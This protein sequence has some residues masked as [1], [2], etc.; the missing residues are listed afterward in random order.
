MTVNPTN[1]YV[2][3]AEEQA[4][5]LIADRL[6]VQLLRLHQPVH[7]ASEQARSAAER[8][9]DA[10]ISIANVPEAADAVA[11]LDSMTLVQIR[12][13]EFAGD[14]TLHRLTIDTS[15]LSQLAALPAVLWIDLYRPPEPS[16]QREVHLTL[17]DTL[18]TSTGILGPVLGDHRQWIVDKGLGGYKTAVRLAILDTGFDK[19]SLSSSPSTNVHPDFKNSS[20]QSFVEV[21]LVISE[22]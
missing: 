11:L 18:V 6:P 19:G 15:L 5:R 13:P 9:I 20:G 1:G 12:P 17:G 22:R 21:C 7:K 10:T 2:V 8:F 4:L 16:G 14:R 3:L